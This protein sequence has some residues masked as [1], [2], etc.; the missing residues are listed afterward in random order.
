LGAFDVKPF[1]SLIGSPSNSG[2][3]I[4]TRNRRKKGPM[5]SKIKRWS[6]SRKAELVLALLKGTKQIIDV[7]RENDL[8]QSEVEKWKEDFLKAGEQGLKTHV[9]PDED[10]EVKDLRAKVGE[11]LLELDARK[12]LEALTKSKRR[13]S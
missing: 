1:Y 8:K 5:E 6:S 3:G 10:G 2:Q 13:P 9:A 12:K 7:C 11:L 4:I